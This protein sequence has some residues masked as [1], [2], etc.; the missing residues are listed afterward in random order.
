MQVSLYTHRQNLT[1]CMGCLL[2][3]SNAYT[4]CK[5][6]MFAWSAY[7]HRGMP[8]FT[9]KTVKMDTR[10][11]R[12]QDAYSYVKIGIW[13]AYIWGC[14]YSLDTGLRGTLTCWQLCVAM[15]IIDYNIHGVATFL[16]DSEVICMEPNVRYTFIH[17]VGI[18]LCQ[19]LRRKR[20][21]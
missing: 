10:M 18:A 1:V 21:E 4:H 11:P 7:F 6:S 14:L 12:H 8:T 20:S 9:V 2:L 3:H 5:I 17:V 15:D 13:D 16:I 19:A